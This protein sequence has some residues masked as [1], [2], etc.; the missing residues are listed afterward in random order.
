MFKMCF[1]THKTQK[2]YSPKTKFFSPP[3]GV[4]L[5][6]FSMF[7]KKKMSKNFMFKMCFRP[8]R[9]QKIYSPTT[10]KFFPLGLPRRPVLKKKIAKNFMFKMCFR[11]HRTQKI[12]SPTTNFFFPL[13]GWTQFFFRRPEESSTSLGEFRRR[14]QRVFVYNYQNII[15]R[16]NFI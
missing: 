11:P 6:I 12:Y 1:R 16:E 8:H 13:E 14:L 5:K 7:R 9:T 10:K 4:G 3:Q 15:L 2:I